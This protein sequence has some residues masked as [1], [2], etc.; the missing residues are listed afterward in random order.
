ME[1][2]PLPIMSPKFINEKNYKV[3]L[4]D[5]E[6][7]LLIRSDNES[8]NFLLSPLTIKNLYSYE[9]IYNCEKLSKINKIFLAF[10]S[11][12]TISQS[13]EQMIENNKYS[14]K[15]KNEN[16]EINLK[17]SLFEKLIDI[18]LILKKKN[19]N[20]NQ[21][22]NNIFGQL[23]DLNDKIEKIMKE[24]KN[25]N[26]EIHVLKEEN[27]K[28]QNLNE[29]I[30][31]LKE[32]NKKNEKIIQILK[33]ENQKIKKSNEDLLNLFHEFKKN[34]KNETNGEN[35]KFRFRPGNNYT[36]SKNGLVATKTK[37][38]NKNS[39]WCEWNCCIIGD[40]EI[41]KNK[42]SKWKI[43]INSIANNLVN[44]W[45]ILI[46]IGPD[47]INEEKNFQRKCW[48]FICGESKIKIKTNEKDYINKKGSKRIKNNDIIEVIV[49]RQNGNL[50]FEV[51]GI[52][53]GIACSDIPKD[54]ILYPV[55]NIYDENQT[56]EILD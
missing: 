54:D 2:A 46:G 43:R 37:T 26:D 5:I 38:L 24:N 51:N 47:N 25:L 52:N 18:N 53:Y 41:P 29:E 6:Y 48:S 19:I 49:D 1:E 50:S 42:I 15:E 34:F 44:S 22:N 3:K 20:Q 14:I 56:I 40:K 8:I 16:V 45:N 4:N 13:I 9:E 7:N 33:E 17:V 23:T 32:E 30:Q 12:E 21:I 39:I 31:I 36:I 28:I 55:I 10:D 35:F 27:K 11:I